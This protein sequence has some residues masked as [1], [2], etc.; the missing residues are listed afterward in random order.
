MARPIIRTAPPYPKV[1]FPGFLSLM[2]KAVLRA[3]DHRRQARAF[4]RAMTDPHL[5][6]D[7]GLPEVPSA[8]ANPHPLARI[9]ELR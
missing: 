2:L 7:I 5:A 1:R 9:G 8:P 3:A 6:R 4:D